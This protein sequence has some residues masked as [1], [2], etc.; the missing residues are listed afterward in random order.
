M[1]GWVRVRL[2]EHVGNH[3]L[4]A[5][6]MPANTRGRVKPGMS[7]RV[8]VPPIAAVPGDWGCDTKFLWRVHDDDVAAICGETPPAGTAVHVCEHEIA[9]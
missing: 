6:M 7:V 9:E 2:S 8:F 3:S 4:D 5:A 1:S